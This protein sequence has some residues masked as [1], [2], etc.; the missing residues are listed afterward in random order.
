[1]RDEDQTTIHSIEFRSSGAA[2]AC[3]CLVILSCSNQLLVGRMLKLEKPAVVIGRDEIADFQVVDDGVSRRHVRLERESDGGWRLLDL[4]STNGTFINGRPAR[5]QRLADGDRIQIGRTTVLKFGVQDQIEESYQRSLYDRA[6][7]DGLTGLYN[8]KFFIDALQPAVAASVRHATALSLVMLDIDHFKRIND[9]F[10]H[11]AGDR[12]LREVSD[13]LTRM[14]RTEDLLARYGG[15]EFA[16]L[17]RDT[18]QEQ[19][20]RCAERCRREVE[21]QLLDPSAL[22][23]RVTLS[24]GVAC[25]PDRELDDAEALTA[26]ADRELY[27]AKR[28]GRNRVCSRARAPETA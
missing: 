5:Q 1:M 9:T 23:I 10:G 16:L 13:A 7:R 28:L 2:N 11:P 27:E 17:L 15:E 20:E 18:D 25:L 21:A 19:A 24:A 3:A 22:R 26:A 12:V 6:T 4:G 8:K 14:V